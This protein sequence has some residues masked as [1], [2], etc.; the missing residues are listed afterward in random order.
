MANAQALKTIFEVSKD[1]Y[2]PNSFKAQM[3]ERIDAFASGT[4]T[5]P[6]TLD[7]DSNDDSS[8][9]TATDDTEKADD[10]P[11]TPK[12]AAAAAKEPSN[13]VWYIYDLPTSSVQQ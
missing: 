13:Y 11:K 3:A 12:V 1:V 6:L 9:G 8:V 5:A 2:S 7:S 4:S 10:T